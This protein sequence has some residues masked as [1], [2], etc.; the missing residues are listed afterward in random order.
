MCTF[1]P[2]RWIE[3]LAD[4]EGGSLAFAQ[5]SVFSGGRRRFS[6]TT[7][8]QQQPFNG[9]ALVGLNAKHVARR[10]RIAAEGYGSAILRSL[11]LA[12][13]ARIL[14]VFSADIDYFWRAPVECRN[15]HLAGFNI[16]HSL[17]SKISERN[18]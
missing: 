4:D 14:A 3:A 2:A 1:P 5:F 7:R 18:Q 12:E 9:R 17:E 11:S 13:N 6:P 8:M 10:G 15:M 16:F